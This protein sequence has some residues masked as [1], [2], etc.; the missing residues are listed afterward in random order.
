MKT[1]FAVGRRWRLKNAA[2][3]I[4]QGR[5]VFDFVIVGAP[6]YEW[7]KPP[8]Q[9][10]YKRCRL[11]VPGHT[12]KCRLSCPHGSEQDYNHAHLKRCAVLVVEGEE[13]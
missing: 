11:E 1:A 13:K 8:T 7:G 10:R 3:R 12:E 2:E 4:A 6:Q 5:E 9:A